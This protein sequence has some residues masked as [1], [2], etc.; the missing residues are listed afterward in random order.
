MSPLIDLAK[1][2]KRF[3]LGAPFGEGTQFNSKRT[4]AKVGQ[5]KAE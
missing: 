1:Q 2:G 4:G 3:S 5:G